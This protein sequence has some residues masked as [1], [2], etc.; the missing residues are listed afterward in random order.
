M[1]SVIFVTLTNGEYNDHWLGQEVSGHRAL[2]WCGQRAGGEDHLVGPGTIVA[3]RDKKGEYGFRLV[4]VVAEKTL[5]TPQAGRTPATYRLDVAVSQEQRYIARDLQYG[6][7]THFT[8]LH[9]L[10]IPN[11]WGEFVRGIYSSL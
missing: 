6:R 8:V 3:V 11:K 7:K 4:G 1:S 5:L 10:G 9:E 2:H